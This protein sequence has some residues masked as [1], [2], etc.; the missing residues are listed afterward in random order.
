MSTV[1]F[2]ATAS[3]V[4]PVM[5]VREADHW[6]A[7]LL[8][9]VVAQAER[10]VGLTVT[11]VS[12]WYL[13]A[14]DLGIYSGLRLLLDN[15][16]R[17]SL[18][19]ALGAIQ[20]SLFLRAQGRPSDADR[21]LAVASTA[22]T[23]TSS[24]Y[25]ISLAVWGATLYRDHG[26][27][28]GLGLVLVGMLAVLK[29]KQDFQV[30][31]LRS[32]SDFAALGR[33]A[34]LQNLVFGISAA[35]A[36]LAFGFWGLM[37][38]LVLAFAVQGSLLNRR[39][40]IRRFP[41]VWDWRMSSSLAA[42][43]LPILAAN[44]AWS[45]LATLDRAIILTRMTD[46]AAL[47]GHYSLAILATSWCD[48]LAGRLAQVVAPGY[49][50]A[51]GQGASREAVLEKA[52]SAAVSLAFVL[53]PLGVWAVVAGRPILPRLFPNLATGAEAFAPLLP[54]TIALCATWPLREAWIAIDRPWLS[55][56]LAGA[57][58][59]SMFLS[60]ESTC[61]SGSI[62]AVAADASRFRIAAAVASFV[63]VA[64]ATRWSPRRF[65][66]WGSLCLWICG[67]ASLARQLDSLR[68]PA[69]TSPETIARDITMLALATLLA[70]IGVSV[71]IRRRLLHAKLGD[72]PQ[73]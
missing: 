70:A 1:G 65:A 29:R 30:A 25:G 16:N 53:V 73:T 17:S 9:A 23:L 5:T 66:C 60:L 32:R 27:P 59:V 26:A 19:V 36:I 14:A 35:A 42:T 57:F 15:T 4:E 61:E 49:R 68:L 39:P 20:K 48:D 47:A 52:E 3:S 43:G 44:T 45:L 46:G 12:R 21:V 64:C 41:F 71:L 37:G 67:W 56:I 55:A 8:L 18:G 2:G 62:A 28:W 54:G 69:G 38:A 50:T 33:I 51:F 10:I 58:S 13:S 11:F 34:L 7:G 22:N 63:V 31:V 72:E 6:R 40:G 24:V